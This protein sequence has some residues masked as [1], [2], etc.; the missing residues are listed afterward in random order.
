MKLVSFELGGKPGIGVAVGGGLRGLQYDAPGYP[1]SLDGLLA[2]GADLSAVG[3]ALSAAPEF[4]AGAA[5]FL[6]PVSRPSKILC[7]GLNYRAHSAETGLGAPDYP[8][9]FARFPNTLVGHGQPLLVPAESAQ[10]DFEAELA[11]VIGRRCRRVAKRDALGCVAGYSAFNDASVRD[12]QMKTSQWTMG[13]NFDATG[14]FGPWLVTPDELPPGGDGLRVKTRLNG[15]VEQDG[16]TA[17]MV[18]KVAELIALLSAAMTLEPGDVIATG[19]PSGVGY[20]RKPPLFMK[21]GDVCEVEVEG[22]GVL[23]NPIAAG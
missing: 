6:P 21:A 15:R 14:G 2:S 17:D 18:F 4:D 22:V 16:T 1:G 8:A 5:R 11:V 7:V 23:R 9:I 12:Y 10:L 19:T 3:K 20:S 13:K